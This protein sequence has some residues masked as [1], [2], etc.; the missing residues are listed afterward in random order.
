MVDLLRIETFLHAAEHQNFSEAARIL[1]L[2][3]PTVSHHIKNLEQELGVI[4]FERDGASISLTDAGRL[5]LPWARRMLR[6]SIE[7]QEMMDSIKE[8]IAGN[9]QIACSTTAGK[10]VLPQ[11][12]ARFSRRHP[13]INTKLLRCAPVSVVTNL[14]EKEANLGVVSF[15]LP[16]EEVELQEF[17]KDLIIFIVP[18]NHP[19]ISRSS[20]QPEDLLEESIIMRESSSGTRK[21]VLSELAKYDISLDDL[22]T[23]MEIGNAEAIVRTVA[24]GYGVSF[25]SK[26]AAACALERGNVAAVPVEGLNLVRTIY[27]VR[28]KLKLSNRPADAFWSFIHDPSNEDLIELASRGD[29]SYTIQDV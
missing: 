3:Q 25:V 5:L 19:F 15:E 16:G 10:Y 20:I 2:S 28:K 9:L 23:F 29:L 24:A 14:L 8:G 18:K 27:M 1:H 6:D 7:L 11:L 21:I 12:A 26:L 13:N 22:N 4:L 17:F